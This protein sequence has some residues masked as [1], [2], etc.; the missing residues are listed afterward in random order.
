MIR[1]AAAKRTTPDGN[2]RKAWPSCL[3]VTGAHISD[4]RQTVGGCLAVVVKLALLVESCGG[5][6][7]QTNATNQC[8]DWK[9][10]TSNTTC[11][12]PHF[13]CALSG[14]DGA[15]REH[16]MGVNSRPSSHHGTYAVI[17]EP[18]ALWYADH[19]C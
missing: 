9:G 14:A 1:A 3:Y 6:R 2:A 15:A 8:L 18:Q 4:C 5:Q 11:S 13:L 19:V 17:T 16:E 7:P 12:C 10:Q